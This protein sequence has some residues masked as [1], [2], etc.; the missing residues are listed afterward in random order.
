MACWLIT[1]TDAI[2]LIQ[3]WLNFDE[4]T[5][6]YFINIQLFQISETNQTDDFLNKMTNFILLTAT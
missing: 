4:Y 1:T 2:D 5:K 6:D 3:L